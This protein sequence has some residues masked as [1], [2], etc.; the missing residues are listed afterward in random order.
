MIE[1]ADLP[2]KILVQLRR[3]TSRRRQRMAREPGD[4]PREMVSSV[5]PGN[6][7]KRRTVGRRDDARSDHERR[8]HMSQ[9]VL[10]RSEHRP[11]LVGVGD[12]ED[13]ARAVRALDEKIL[14]ALARQRCGRSSQAEDLERDGLG[15][16]D[17]EPWRLF[18]DATCYH[19]EL[20]WG[21]ALR[22]PRA[23]RRRDERLGT[24]ARSA[25]VAR[26]RMLACRT[27]GRTRTLASSRHAVSTPA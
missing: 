26:Y 19:R 15:V 10:L 2:T 24:P 1:C 12:L 8:R 13:D 18:E 9:R 25:V 4:R 6:V 17:V 20:P 23:S 16:A 21:F 5:A 3:S 7:R 27:S 11:R 22:A 14:N